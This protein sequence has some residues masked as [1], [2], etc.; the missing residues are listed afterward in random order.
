MRA[1]LNERQFVQVSGPSLAAA[2]MVG[3]QLRSPMGPTG[4]ERL[5]FW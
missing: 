5:A 3:G 4:S 1:S 2:F